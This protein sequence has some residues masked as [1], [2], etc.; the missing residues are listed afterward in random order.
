MSGNIPKKD[1]AIPPHLGITVKAAARLG[2][3]EWSTNEV[4]VAGLADL[5]SFVR[6]NP[7]DAPIIN[8][9][10]LEPVPITKN[11]INR[12]EHLAKETNGKVP[13]GFAAI[14][15][16]GVLITAI[17]ALEEKTQELERRLAKLEDNHPG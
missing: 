1:L 3:G 15:R 5:E 6:T 8:A 2:T 13:L 7:A 12:F 10:P 11:V 16:I 9:G 17:R 14:Q 4:L